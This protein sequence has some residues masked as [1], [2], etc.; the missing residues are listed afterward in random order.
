MKRAWLAVLLMALLLPL[1]LAGKD[2][3]GLYDQSTLNYWQ[4]RYSK[5]LLWNY[6]NTILPVLTQQERKTLKGL[7]IRFP[8]VGQIGGD[9]LEYYSGFDR[10]LP[11]VVIPILSVKFF[12]DLAIAMAWLDANGYS[13]GT[14][15]DWVAILKY[16]P[17]RS[18]PGGRY[19]PPLRTLQIPPN[20]TRNPK[21]DAL[22]QKI[23]KSAIIWIL[24]HELGHI[25]YR[26]PGYGRGA[27]AEQIQA[28]EIQADRFATEMMR[29]IGVAPVG[30]AFF[31]TIAIHWLP[32]RSD[33]STQRAWRDFISKANHPL[34]TERLRK[35]AVQINGNAQD[36]ARKEPNY[37]NALRAIYSAA[38]EIDKLSRFLANE[39]LQGTIKRKALLTSQLPDPFKPR[40][41]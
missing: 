12:D 25:F 17:P 2:L 24:G 33:F 32:N 28:N 38:K 23:L 10:G 20:A 7:R 13:M 22:S 37:S 9:P 18:F 4:G 16:L 6:R 11:V 30:L 27:S 29:R 19:L 15:T 41:R 21:V 8:L 26:H 39:E 5:N 3:S 36:F 34:S 31:F 35:L 1:S 40:R 14:V